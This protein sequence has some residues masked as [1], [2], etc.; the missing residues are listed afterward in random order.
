[1]ATYHNL[2]P[3]SIVFFT[4]WGFIDMISH[5]EVFALYIE[6]YESIP[7]IH[8]CL[9]D[10][11]SRYKISKGAFVM[12]VQWRMKCELNLYNGYLSEET[13]LVMLSKHK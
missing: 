6:H 9:I 4:Y 3:I 7:K 13:K 12:W 11:V 8:F 2:L 5:I 1:M 10:M